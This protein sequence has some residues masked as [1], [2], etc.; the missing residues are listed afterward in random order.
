VNKNLSAAL[1]AAQQSSKLAKK[2]AE[3]WAVVAQIYVKHERL[4]EALAAVEKAC[5]LATS[6]RTAERYDS[7]RQQIRA[8]IEK[9][10]K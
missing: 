1:E 5:Q 9:K 6:K 8:E 2:N 4:E 3:A 7:L 10:R